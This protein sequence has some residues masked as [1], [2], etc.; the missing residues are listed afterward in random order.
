MFAVN[1]QHLFLMMFEGVNPLSTLIWPVHQ[2]GKINFKKLLHNVSARVILV[3]VAIRNQ[4]SLKDHL[5]L[6]N[7]VGPSLM[8]SI[9]S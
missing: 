8:I 4:D 9:I 5:L 7:D 6:V 1:L 2:I 3:F